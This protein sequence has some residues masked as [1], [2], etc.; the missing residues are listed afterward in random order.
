[1]KLR[2]YQTSAVDQ[3]LKAWKD[4]SPSVL[5]V[6]PTGCGKTVVFG[7][8]IGRRLP[9][10]AMIIA[11]R[12][13]LIWQ[14]RDKVKQI[15][16]LP[17]EIE[18]GEQRAQ[19]DAGLFT[20][21]AQIIVST[22][23]THTAGGDGSGR[24]SKFDPKDFETLVIDEAHHA[25]AA[26]YRKVIDWYMTNPHLRV[27]GVTATP[28]RTDEQ[29][30]GQVFGQV[31]FDF[32]VQDMIEDGWLVPVRQDRVSIESLDFSSVRTTAGDLNGA[33][34]AAVMEQEESLH[35]VAGATID[36]L[37]DKRGIGFAASVEQA[38]VLS[39]IFNRH[40]LGMSAYVS[41]KTDKQERA[42]I[43]A[44]FAK[45]KIQFLWN[46]GVFTEG[47]D[48][49][50]VE[51]IAMAR[52]TESRALYAQMAGR[53]TRPHQTIVNQLNTAPASV[54]RRCLIARSCKPEC[55]IVDFVGNSGRHNLMSTADILG[56]NYSEEVIELAKAKARELGSA[57][58]GELLKKSEE[59]I[60]EQEKRRLEE[61]ARKAR[62]VA[63][64]NY[65][66]Q[67]VNPFD[68]LSIKPANPRGW[69]YEKVL[70]EKQRAVLRK[71]GIN[72][73]GIPYVQAKQL[74]TEI[75]SR[76]ETNACSY[77][78]AKILKRFNFPTDVSFDQ[79][80]KAIDA[81]A[82]A[83]WKRPQNFVMP[84]AEPKQPEHVP[85]GA[86][87]DDNVPF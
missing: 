13:E 27:I 58:M 17:V 21:S 71:S 53:A 22:I 34:L 7:A 46:C 72:P 73:D 67:T 25:T 85:A 62:L 61:E 75:I 87:D 78:Q 50:G 56:G 39:E 37:G 49:S 15:T 63:K 76:W 69:D 45:G 31:A 26:S 30:L 51:V 23:Q 80:K 3:T 38:R 33:D 59:E 68:V 9:G 55:R 1:M 19:M 20:P 4:E 83:G 52:P 40:R 32:E 8:I 57:R 86:A 14:A 48:D 47:F 6:M 79:A 42:N 28:D 81:I 64:V 82:S 2:S 54:L 77:K 84:A 74:V 35:G 41:G 24:M 18:M 5:G 10:R 43:V 44:D 12:A 36:I 66:A 29:A 70:S 11:H 60:E 16:G 65:K